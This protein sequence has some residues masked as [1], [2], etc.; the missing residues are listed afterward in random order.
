MVTVKAIIAMAAI[1]IGDIFFGACLTEALAVNVCS[2]FPNQWML[3]LNF[4]EPKL[5]LQNME[6]PL[7]RQ[8]GV[9]HSSYKTASPDYLRRRRA[10]VTKGERRLG[11]TIRKLE[12]SV[13]LSRKEG[14]AR[15]SEK[16]VREETHASSA[17]DS[18]VQNLRDLSIR[19][20][21]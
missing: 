15:E 19:R 5:M 21:D 12:N 7:T 10:L 4:Y 14:R 6:N 18:P 8:L 13:E 2:P 11:R 16:K 17:E 3:A 20:K 1:W 9:N